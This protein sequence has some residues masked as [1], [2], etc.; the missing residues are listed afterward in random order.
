MKRTKPVLLR[1][2][3]RQGDPNSAPRCGAK[4]RKG[5]ACRN[6]A[7]K[8]GRCRLHGGKSTGP[9]SPEGLERSKKAN[10]KHGLYSKDFLSERKNVIALLK[11]K[12]V[13]VEVDPNTFNITAEIFEKAISSKT[14]AVVPVHLFGQCVDMEQLMKVANKHSIFVVEDTAQA[15]GADYTFSD[16]SVKKAGTIGHIGCTSFFP[17]KNLGCYGDGGAIL[18]E[19][20]DLAAKMRSITNHG[21]KIK[22]YHDI[23]GVNSRLDS[24]QASILNIKLKYLDEYNASRIKAADFYD[25]AFASSQKLII[26]KRSEFSTHCFHQYTL[27]CNGINHI[28]LQSYLRSKKIPSMIYYPV[29][30]HRQKAFGIKRFDENNFKVTNQLCNQVISLPMHTELDREQQE[31]ICNNVLEYANNN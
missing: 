10:L 13:M 26:P 29:P 18:T 25:K 12:P 4:T 20:N 21:S 2:G 15:I 19:N 31:Y 1:N 11:L 23:I 28:E 22:Y 27:K 16:G 3:N 6:P 17:S 8:N 9:T 5:P 14:R 30:L 7:M 24:I